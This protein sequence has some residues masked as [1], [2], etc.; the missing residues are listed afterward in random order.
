MD[1]Y[2]DRWNRKLDEILDEMI[3]MDPHIISLEQDA[4]QPRP[5]MKADGPASTKTRERTEGAATAVQAMCGDSCFV[6]RVD[7]DPMCATSSDDDCTGPPAPP[8]SGENA[9]VDNGAAAPK[10]CLPFLGM[11]SPSAA[12]GLLPTSE[13][14]SA[15]RTTFNQPPLRFYS[16]EETGSKTNWRTRILYVS[17]DSSFLPAAHS[18][19][20]AIETKSGEN[21][22]FD[23]GGSQGRLRACPFLGSWREL[24]CGEVMRAGAAG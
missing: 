15:M 8:C 6:D 24:L 13:T 11:R 4:R 10:S 5:A 20:M 7:P 18:Y 1:S 22:A 3:V 19:R 12:G 23:P 21:R 17:Y 9:L 16:T 2:F 14:S